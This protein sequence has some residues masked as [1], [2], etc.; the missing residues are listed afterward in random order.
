MPFLV[1]EVA[2]MD[3]LMRLDASSEFNWKM[4]CG[5]SFMLMVLLVSVND[6]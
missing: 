3:P 5:K 2:V 1:M 4:Q 6:I